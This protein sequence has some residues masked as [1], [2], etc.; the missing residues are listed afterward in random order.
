MPAEIS[1][2]AAPA[3]LDAIVAIDSVSFKQPWARTSF[4][5]AFVDPNSVVLLVEHNGVPCGFGVA[6]CV[7]DEAEIATL[8]VDAA[9][10]GKGVGEQIMRALLDECVTRGAVVV[11]LE[12]RPSN[13]AAQSLYRRLGFESVGLRPNYYADGE[14]AVIMKWS[15]P[16]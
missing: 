4:E 15:R 16:N 13:L 9:V 5:R 7:G 1:R 3:D 12:V 14:A 8:A 10:R 11:F 2:R 6:W